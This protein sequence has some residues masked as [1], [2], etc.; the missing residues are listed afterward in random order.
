MGDPTSEEVFAATQDIRL[1]AGVWSGMAGQLDSAAEVA[2]GLT[3]NAFHF[4]GLGHLAGL[5]DKYAELQNRVATMLSSGSVTFDAMAAALKK[6]ADE[7]DE[8]ER[9]AVHRMKNIY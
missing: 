6:S 9:N 8:D 2:R 5:D 1:D 7:Y 3:L 4:S